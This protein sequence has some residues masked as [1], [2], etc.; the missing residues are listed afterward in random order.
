MPGSC[1][2]R[3]KRGREV[4]PHVRSQGQKPGGPHARRATAK[5][6]YPTSKVRGSGRE[7]QAATAQKRRRGATPC[8]RSGGL[9]ERS[10]PASEV[11][12]R[13]EE[14]PRVRGQGRRL[15]GDTP[16][17]QAG[18]QGRRQGGTTPRPHALGQGLLP[19]GPTPRPRSRGCKGAGAPRGATP[20]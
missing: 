18:G 5:R 17:P 11:G 13:R 1:D 12:G 16:R 6:N 7:C 19:G 8:L 14:L 2:R 20:R 10:Y 4:L 9:A 15:G 3:T